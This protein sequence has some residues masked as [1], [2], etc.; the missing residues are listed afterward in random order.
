MCCINCG[1]EEQLIVEYGIIYHQDCY[2]S[3]DW[4]R[5]QI[6]EQRK[7]DRVEVD[8]KELRLWQQENNKK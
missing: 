7:L 4:L 8:Q 3:C 1:G 2:E 6:E 5:E